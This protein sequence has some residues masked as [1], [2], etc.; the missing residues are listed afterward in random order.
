MKLSEIMTEEVVSTAPSRSVTDA[1]EDMRARS[2]H[3]LVVV[4]DGAVVGVLSERDL[5]DRQVGREVGDVMHRDVVTA[6]TRT[7]VRE[8]ARLMRGRSIGCL[9][10][11][12]QGRVAGI[13]T[14][15]DLLDLIGAGVL[16]TSDD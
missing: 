10:V 6:T 12:D 15:A 11:L 1:F 5:G 3:H 4:E 9:P 8:A 2:L 13:V 7:T 16:R 14:T